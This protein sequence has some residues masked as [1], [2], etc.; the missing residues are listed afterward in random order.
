MRWDEMSNM[1][2]PLAL[3]DAARDAMYDARE[4]TFKKVLFKVIGN[5][6]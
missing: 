2:V 5:R 4:I 3:A 6:K 1:N